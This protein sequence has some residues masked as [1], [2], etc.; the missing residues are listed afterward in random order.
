MFRLFARYRLALLIAALLLIGAAVNAALYYRQS[1][2]DLRRNLVDQSLPLSGDTIF[3]EIDRRILRP[4][5]LAE[6]M[7]RDSFLQDWLQEGETD[8]KRIS[9]YLR[10]FDGHDGVS[11]S[12]LVSERSRRYYYGGGVLKTVS[13]QD[14]DDGWYFRSIRMST[15]Y[16][17]NLDRDM[18]NGGANTVFIN[19]RLLGG[20]GK[21]LGILGVGLRLE[22]L[23]QRLA[24]YEARFQRR[25]YFVDKTGRILLSSHANR[26]SASLADLPELKALSPRILAGDTTPQTIDFLRDGHRFL[27][28]SRYLAK[29]SWHLV[30]EQDETQ[31]LSEL[32]S[33]MRA[34]LAV[35]S[36][37]LLLVMLA[38]LITLQRHEEKLQSLATTDPLTGCLNRLAFYDL[39][40]DW[41]RHCKRIDAQP[42]LLV[43][44]IDHFKRVNDEYGHQTGD[45]VLREI[46]ELV[47]SQ[48]RGN[49]M[50]I[51]WG[52]EE[53]VV[54]ATSHGEDD[55]LAQRLRQIVSRHAV[56]LDQGRKLTV[57]ISIGICQWLPP[58][59]L[60]AAVARADQAM[61]AAKQAGRNQVCW[62]APAATTEQGSP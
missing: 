54:L 49:D 53:F 42:Q 17:I 14:P 46:A 59:T 19:Y 24:E 43:L 3:S 37:V 41:L 4:L 1:R 52:G 36:A 18:T 40:S 60:E 7:A 16:Q 15:D 2:E 44:D 10:G 23:R 32:D 33:T 13:E 62:A 9:R 61:Y 12:F 48:L 35:N 55:A 6:L 31:A 21:L 5:S 28:T 58:E 25:I 8:P 26:Q 29:L 30:V 27:L 47:H 57:T 50:L 56:L 22:Q 20:D 34:N 39:L 38:V 51:R 11:G 45:Q